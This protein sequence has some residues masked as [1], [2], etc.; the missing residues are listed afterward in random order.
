MTLEALRLGNHEVKA[1]EPV[2]EQQENV[3][4]IGDPHHIGKHG[5]TLGQLVPQHK[6][7]CL[8][9]AVEA[10]HRHRV[11]QVELRELQRQN[12]KQVEREA[13]GPVMSKENIPYNSYVILVL[14]YVSFPFSFAYI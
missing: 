1:G 10:E 14:V 8:E 9:V 13:L 11:A 2:A 4:Q 12:G 5:A 3:R 6:A 7:V